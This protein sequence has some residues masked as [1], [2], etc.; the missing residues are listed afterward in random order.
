MTMPHL[1]NCPHSAEGWCLDCV[2]E[3]HDWFQAQV[4]QFMTADS[5][6][7]AALQAE[8]KMLIGLLRRAELALDGYI[9]RATDPNL[10]QEI[11]GVLD[12]SLPE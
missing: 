3:L 6:A 12:E 10:P 9:V 5:K 1:M 11:E 4:E 8:N 2:K 7:V